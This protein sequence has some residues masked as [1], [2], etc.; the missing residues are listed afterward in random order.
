MVNLPRC[1]PFLSS[2]WGSEFHAQL[3][4]RKWHFPDS[5]FRNFLGGAIPRTSLQMA[6]ALDARNS[7]M[8]N[9]FELVTG[10]NHF[11]C[12]YQK[13]IN[14]YRVAFHNVQNISH[15]NATIRTRLTVDCVQ[16]LLRRKGETADNTSRNEI[17]VVHTTQNFDWLMQLM[18]RSFFEKLH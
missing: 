16:S 12:L 3:N 6:H 7:Y 4:C 13:K 9:Y 10:Y 18:D 8:T 15:T 5:S 2:N 17:C 1:C 14:I 11:L